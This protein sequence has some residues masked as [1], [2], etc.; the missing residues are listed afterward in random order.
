M[1]AEQWIEVL[2]WNGREIDD[3]R[4]AG[5]AY[6]QQGA[7]QIALIFFQGISVLTTPTS[8]DLQTLG[9][10][11]LQ[12]GD[13]LQALEALDRALKLDPT[14]L[15]AQLNRAKALLMLGKKPQAVAQAAL[16]MRT[17]SADIAS[18]AAAL[19]LSLSA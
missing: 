11:H 18:Q 15:T 2:G 3:L 16:L 8:Y 12:L 4:T 14:N 5:Y 1:R 13:P 17:A 10:L 9:A 6:I 19:L 7:Y